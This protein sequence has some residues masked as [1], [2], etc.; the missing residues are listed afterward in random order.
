MLKTLELTN[1]QKHSHL[2]IPLMAGVNVLHGETD[3]GKSCIVRAFSWLYFGEPQGDVVRKEGTKKT[4]V[5]GIFDNGIVVER[6]K[7]KTRNA[8]EL[9]IPGSKMKPFDS[10]NRNVP[11]EI[12]KVLRTSTIKVDKEEII[13]NVAKQISLPFLLDKSGIFRNKLFNQLTGNDITDKA[14]QSFNK[15][16]LHINK[17]EKLE[18]EHLE[19]G[20]NALN[21]L[22]EEKEKVQVVYDKLAKTY[23]EIKEKSDTYEKLNDYLKKLG[24]IS[25]EIETANANLKGIKIINDNELFAIEVTIKQLE[26]LNEFSNELKIVEKELSNTKAKLEVISPEIDVDFLDLKEKIDKIDYL[27]KSKGQLDEIEKNN[28]K[29]IESIII[30][31]KQVEEGEKSYK[32]MLTKLKVC[33]TCKQ[34]IKNVEKIKL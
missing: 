10:I 34:E 12:Q 17:V 25:S 9:T 19:E 24:E 30:A 5:K 8:Y 33:P 4:S 6:I 13:L 23:K 26:R 14:L 18:K 15:D 2:I 7:S 20:K 32:K 29:I 11:E 27:L 22:T 1:F 21:E 16:I 3:A 28:N 31:T